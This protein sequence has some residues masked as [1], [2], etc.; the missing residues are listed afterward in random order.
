M[1]K[2]KPRRPKK[3]IYCYKKG[4]ASARQ[5]GKALRILRIAHD[6]SVYRPRPYDTIINWGTSEFH[7]EDVGPR[8][9][10]PPTRVAV[11]AN[12]LRT[13][14]ALSGAYVS[15]PAFTTSRS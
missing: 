2:L 7:L 15:I 10:N 4:S 14:R 8:I 11:C 3:R 13:F 12:K 1:A 9:L 6:V 5:L